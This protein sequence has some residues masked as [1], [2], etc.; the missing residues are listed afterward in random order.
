MDKDRQTLLS[1]AAPRYT[2]LVLQCSLNLQNNKNCDGA[3]FFKTASPTKDNSQS[4]R[5]Q[6]TENHFPFI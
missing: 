1:D 3:V 4:L 5:K 6:H 2:N